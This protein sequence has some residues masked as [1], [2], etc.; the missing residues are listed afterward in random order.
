MSDPAADDRTF[1]F[2]DIEGSTRRWEHHPQSMALALARHDALMRDAI[3]GEGGTVFKT[4]GDAFCAVFPTPEAAIAAAVR[5]QR[6]LAAETW[7]EIGGLRVRMAIHTGDAE[8]RDDDYFGPNVNRVAR[9]LGAAHGGQVLVSGRVADMAQLP[10]DSGV[11][12]RDLGRHRLRDLIETERLY[13]VLIPD[14]PDDF[15]PPKTLDAQLRGIPAPPTP[16]LGREREVAAV[17]SLLGIDASGR[18]APDGVRLV[19]LTGPGGAGKTRLALAIAHDAFL[20]FDDGV[21][22]VDLAPVRDPDLVLPAIAQ[23]LGIREEP[24]TPLL[25]TLRATL[26]QRQQLLLLDNFEQVTGAASVVTE[27]LARCPNV[28]ILTTSRIPLRLRGEREYPVGPLALP[29]PLDD[30]DR[31][32]SF[33][34]AADSPAVRLFVERIQAVKPAF[35][36]TSD[37]VADVVTICRRLDGLPLALELVAAW[38]K[39]LS[40]EAMRARLESGRLSLTRGARDLP[41]RQQT[42]HSTIAWSYDLLRPGEQALFRRLAVFVG[43]W[44]L[45]AAETVGAGAEGT[46]DVL[47]QLA[48]LVDASLVWQVEQMDEPRFRMLETIREFGLEQLQAA[49]VAA[50]RRAHADFFLRLAQ[51][52]RPDLGG[53]RQAG[54]L[55]RFEIEH[56]NLRAALQWL[57][58]SDDP[59]GGLE[60]AATLWWFWWIRGYLS[61]GR[62]WLAQALAVAGH[63]PDEV[64]VRALTGAGTLAE[65]QGDYDQAVPF[66]EDALMMCRAS[67]DEAGMARALDSLGTIAQD[68]GDYAQATA[69]HSQALALCRRLGD[70]HGEAQALINLGTDAAYQ[71]AFDRAMT[72]YTE[73]LAL[74][75]TVGDQLS[76]AGGLTNVGNVAFLQ[77]G[78]DSAAETYAEALALYREL[79]DKHGTALVLGNLGEVAQQQGDIDRAAT[80]YAQAL[81]LYQGLDDKRGTA[82]M[83]GNLSQIARTQGDLPRADTLLAQ[84]VAL[85]HGVGDKE[86]VI[87]GVETAAMFLITRSELT[88]GVRLFAAAEAARQEI[89]AP[90]PEVYDTDYAPNLDEARAGLG[91]VAFGAA[92]AVGKS[93]RLE[94]AVMD[95]L[96]IADP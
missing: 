20:S 70:R 39:L 4:V 64:R 2:S 79:G 1:L 45:D 59:V 55:D 43:G 86:A 31:Q 63:A 51:D 23:A 73:G 56:D 84:S 19:T 37:N 18:R 71:G 47:D 28:Q 40:P 54:W 38:A 22:F 76:I 46:D 52:A 17:R 3:E 49:E 27:L 50:T 33:L 91:A 13:Q 89:G 10:A 66:H 48:L 77:G 96:T 29:D 41:E 68:L 85:Y 74:L 21:A 34:A 6:A 53:E 82:A 94:Q 35:T 60:L 15:P 42:I 26:S 30:Q 14:L 88:R 90:V 62:D 72:L 16:L 44:T 81:P 36:L 25:D 80:L 24:G 75:R 92:W 32:P 11:G 67:G 65:A 9:L 5:A 61:E 93:L 58:A 69:H 87:R 8:R 7:V 12:V 83:L 95:A 57:L 78:F